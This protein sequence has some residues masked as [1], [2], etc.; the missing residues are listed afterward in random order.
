MLRVS[1]DK[2]PQQGERLL[3]TVMERESR[4]VAVM[5]NAI[6]M[7]GKED[8]VEFCLC[9]MVPEDE[10]FVINVQLGG[11]QENISAYVNESLDR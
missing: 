4:R 6:A 7:Q 9:R 2:S 11:R 10:L 8:F 1:F 5:S 3:L